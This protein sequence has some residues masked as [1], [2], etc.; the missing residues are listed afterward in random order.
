M[1]QTSFAV[2]KS[3]HHG[4]HS[5]TQLQLEK[6]MDKVE[7]F[8]NLVNLAAVDGKFTQEEVDFLVN[9]AQVWGIPSDEFETAL[10]GISEGNIEIKIPES[11]EDRVHLMRE[12]IKL[13]AS[14]GELA[15]TE[16]TLCATA[17]ARMD[18]TI[19][20][21]NQIFQDVIDSWR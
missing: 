21:F 9:R 1:L 15:E 2:S 3:S 17:S 14:D 4:A 10:A 11:L 16:K 13:M 20:E 18:F 12:M 8:H 6:T 19:D 5:D 7:L